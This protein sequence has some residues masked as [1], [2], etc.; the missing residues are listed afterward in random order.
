[1]QGTPCSLRGV[2][3]TPLLYHSYQ[4][5]PCHA[6]PLPDTSRHFPTLVTPWPLPHPHPQAPS[7]NCPTPLC[8]KPCHQLG[9]RLSPIGTNSTSHQQLVTRLVT[10]KCPL[11]RKIRFVT[12]FHIILTAL[13]PILQSVTKKRIDDKYGRGRHYSSPRFLVEPAQRAALSNPS[14]LCYN[15]RWRSEGRPEEMSLC[16]AQP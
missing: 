4:R 11:T 3:G 15:T 7:N 6:T 12:A 9:R 16:D 13:S 10:N 14:Q 2:G 1:M 5:R 8:D